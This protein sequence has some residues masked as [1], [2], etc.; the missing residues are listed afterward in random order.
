MGDSNA[1]EDRGFCTLIS[2]RCG[3]RLCFR[4][5]NDHLRL[6]EDSLEIEHVIHPTHGASLGVI[7]AD[8]NLQFGMRPILAYTLAKSVWQYYS[9][10]WMKTVWTKD[11]I[12]F[13]EMGQDK[14]LHYFFKP[15]VSIKFDNLEEEASD[16]CKH[17][18]AVHR[19]PR[20]L[21]LAMMLLEIGTGLPISIVGRDEPHQWDAWTVNEQYKRLKNI[22]KDAEFEADCKFPRYRS[23]I[24]K[25]LDPKL[26]RCGPSIPGKPKEKLKE[27][28][29]I[30]YREVVDGLRQLVEGAGWN[31]QFDE[32]EK[33]AIERKK[34]SKVFPSRSQLPHNQELHA[35]VQEASHQ[36]RHEPFIYL[37]TV[38][39]YLQIRG[40][41]S[42]VNSNEDH[43][44]Q[45]I[46]MINDRIKEKRRMSNM[47]S[48]KIAILDTGCDVNAPSLRLPGRKR[49]K[50]WKD[51]V[52]DSPTMADEN[53]HG[54]HLTTLLHQMAPYAE[55]CVMRV[56]K[57]NEE[58]QNSEENIVKVLY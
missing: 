5:T 23:A 47:P 31:S 44:L 35:H 1:V 53:G 12:F 14:E 16:Y 36:K 13:M 17:N 37:E 38:A 18:G 10:D 4:V 6:L 39:L 50:L 33:T 56:A 25:C 41:S 24:E 58:L 30:L 20:I 22:L 51:F 15:Y 42:I 46:N 48:C 26:F 34:S 40:N 11:K 21:A 29:S 2:S 52:E 57:Q 3:S 43:W 55:V 45:S 49:I 32:M 7:L 9:S 8:F 28:Q 19:F 54:T 27:R